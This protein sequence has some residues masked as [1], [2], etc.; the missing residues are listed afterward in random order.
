MQSSHRSH[1]AYMPGNESYI[2]SAFCKF[3]FY[4]FLL[5]VHCR[6]M[7]VRS[8]CSPK[9][10]PFPGSRGAPWPESPR[11]ARDRGLTSELTGISVVTSTL[12]QSLGASA[13]RLVPEKALHTL[14]QRLCRA[15][16]W[17]CLV[18]CCPFTTF[19][20]ASLQFYKF[21]IF[22]YPNFLSHIVTHVSLSIIL[23]F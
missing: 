1:P 9:G 10:K 22:I 11:S 21:R 20:R 15:A 5:V 2:D 8:Y 13:K 14:S 4:I 19:E 23:N 7:A 17:A 12:T 6:H 3:S 16:L 18:C